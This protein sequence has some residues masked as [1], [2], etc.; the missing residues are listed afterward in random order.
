MI[1]FKLA[2][3]L[4]LALTLAITSI[5][6]AAQPFLVMANLSQPV[7]Q[8]TQIAPTKAIATPLHPS[9]LSQVSGNLA[10]VWM[11]PEI[12]HQGALIA[13]GSGSDPIRDALGCSCA[14][15]T[16]QSQIEV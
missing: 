4:S 3:A 8:V 12:P 2:P 16:G 5:L 9:L 14:I 10:S 6:A 7:A 15:C 11:S 13:Q 1:R